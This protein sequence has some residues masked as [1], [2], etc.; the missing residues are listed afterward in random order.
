M[1]I[2]WFCVPAHGHTNPTLA[3]VKE[4][5]DAGH[6]VH[7]FSF[8]LF[9]EKLENLGA[10]FIACDGYASEMEDKENADRIGKDMAFATEL[11]VSSTLALDEMLAENIEA[12]KPDIIVSDSIA[13]WG[14][15]TAKKYNIPYVSSTTTFA[16]NKYS[17]RYIKRGAIEIIKMLLA[18]PRINKQ[19]KKLNWRKNNIYLYG[20]GE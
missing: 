2:A 19:I 12:I 11:L 13:Y 17:S 10:H 4:L 6:E 16:F 14:K 3:L 15:L 1:K 9:K 8:E 20:H 18:M 5:I 7:Y